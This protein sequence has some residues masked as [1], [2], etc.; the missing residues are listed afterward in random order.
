MSDTGQLVMLL[1]MAVVAIGTIPLW[2]A[3]ALIHWG[4]YGAA[5]AMFA[6]VVALWRTRAAL[7]MFGVGW[8]AL[9]FALTAVLALLELLL[10]NS[11][12]LLAVAVLMS[13]MVSALF[14]VTLW[15][16][17]VDTFEITSDANLRTPTADIDAPVP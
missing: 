10:G 7:F 1:K 2:H 15:F 13:W 8:F 16:G 6:S 4:R 11:V 9:S 5:K 17:F 12:L 3:P 14:Y